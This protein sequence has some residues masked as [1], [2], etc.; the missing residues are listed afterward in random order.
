MPELVTKEEYS[1]L[2]INNY[3]FGKTIPKN[4]LEL[5]DFLVRKN[6]KSLYQGSIKWRLTLLP[7]SLEGN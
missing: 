5:D 7:S 2:T 4:E 6:S 3:S 1:D